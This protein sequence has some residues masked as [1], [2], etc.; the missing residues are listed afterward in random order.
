MD[1]DKCG[2]VVFAELGPRS[3]CPTAVGRQHRVDGRGVRRWDAEAGRFVAAAGIEIE[4]RVFAFAFDRAEFFWEASSITGWM[5]GR[6]KA[7]SK[8]SPT[9]R[10]YK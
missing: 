8:V 10:C 6:G 5:D 3:G 1:G 9:P 4:D 7:D 2:V